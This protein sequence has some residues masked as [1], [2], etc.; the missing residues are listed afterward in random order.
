MSSALG[1]WTV[2][3]S[4]FLSFEAAK[5]E[6]SGGIDLVFLRT[7]GRLHDIEPGLGHSVLP[8][9]GAAHRSRNSMRP[10]AVLFSERR[11]ETL[12]LK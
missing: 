4:R 9:N 10:K 5:Q 12:T 7:L 3:E 8:G 6:G 11:H 1:A 2:T